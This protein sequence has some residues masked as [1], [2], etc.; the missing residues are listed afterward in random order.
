MRKLNYEKA[1]QID[2]EKSLIAKLSEDNSQSN[3]KRHF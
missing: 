1:A 2:E 3:T